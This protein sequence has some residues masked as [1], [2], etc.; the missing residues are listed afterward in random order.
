MQKCCGFSRSQLSLEVQGRQQVQCQCA[1]DSNIFAGR[2]INLLLLRKN[3]PDEEEGSISDGPLEIW[4]RW[5]K[6]NTKEQ[7]PT[8]RVS[9]RSLVHMDLRLYIQRWKA[10]LKEV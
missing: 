10:R 5:R 1:M 3:Y 6:M 2:R 4:T 9:P 8:F 7:V